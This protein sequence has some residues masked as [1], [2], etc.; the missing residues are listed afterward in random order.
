MARRQRIQT[1]A[2]RDDEGESGVEIIA[3][4]SEVVAAVPSGDRRGPRHTS[5]T[6]SV[7]HVIRTTATDST[8]R[9]HHAIPPW[10]AGSA[11]FHIRIRTEREWACQHSLIAPPSRAQR[12]LDSVAHYHRRGAWHCHL[13]LLM[14]DHTH[15][16]LSFPPDRAMSQVIGDWKK[17]HARNQAVVWQTNY[18][19]HRIRDEAEFQLKAAYIRN[20]PVAKGLC[21]RPEDWPWV[22]D[23][24]V[25]E[26]PLGTAAPTPSQ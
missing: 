9:L 23:S 10:I 14:P 21:T 6:T 7:V 8:R 12:L 25:L 26:A 5:T 3:T 2:R 17:W 20:N 19:D 15:A 18:F 13:F 16:L 22:I 4:V 1:Q 11:V 24:A